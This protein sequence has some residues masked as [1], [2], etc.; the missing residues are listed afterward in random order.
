MVVN[1][2]K[3]SWRPV[4]SGVP[5]GSVLGPV[6]FNTFI[7]DLDKGIECTLIKFAD[8]TKLCGSVDLLE[9]RQALQRD[10]DRLDRWAGVNCMRFNKA[11]CKVLHLGH[12]NPMQRY[13]LGEEWLESCP[14]EKDL[15][16]LVNSRLNMS[17]QCAQVA[18]KA[19]GILACIKNSVASRSS[20]VIVP[21]YSALVRPHL[22][23]CVQFW[24]P[25]YKRDIEVLERVQRRATK[26]VKGLEQKSY[27]DRLRELGLFSLEKR[28]LRGDLIALYNYLKGGCREVGV[29]IFSQVTS[30]RMR[31]N[32]LKLRQGRFRLDIRK[33]YFTE[34]VV[35]HWNRLPREVVELPSLEVFKRHVCW[36]YNTAQRKQETRRFLECVE[37]NFQTQ[38]VSEPTREGA[39]L[40]LL[41]VNREGLAGDV[42]VGGCLGHSDHEVI[43][44]LILGEVRRG[45]SRTATLDFWR[46]DFGLFRGLADRVPW[47]AVLKGKGV[48][49]GWTFFKKKIVKAEEQAIP[50]CQKT[51]QQ[52]RQLAWLK[53]ELWLELRKKRRVYDL[54][55]KGQ[56]TQEDYKDVVRLCREKIRRTK[57][58]L[59]IN[60]ATAVKDNK[61]CFY[62]Y[63]SNKRT[64]KE[65]LHPLLDVG[66]NIVTKDEE[67][68]EVLNA[69]FASVFNSKTSC[70]PGTQPPELEDR[71][72]EQSEAP[73][74]QEEMVSDLLHHLDTNKSMGLGGMHPRVLRELVG[75]LTK[76]FSILYQQSWLTGEV[77]KCDAHLQEGLE[78]GLGELRA[79]QSD[80]GAEEVYG[81]DHL[82]CHH[83]AHTGHPGDQAQ[84]AWV[85]ERQDKVTCLVDEGKAV[86]VVYL[87]FSKAF[88]TVSHSILL[89]KLAAHG[90]DGCML[91]WLENCL[92]GWVQRV[93]V[94]GVKSSRWLVTSGVP[95]GSVL[96]PVLFNVFISDLDEGIKYTLI[97]FADDTTL[98]RNVD[99]LESRKILQRDLDRL[100]RWAKTNCMRFNKAKCWVLHL[101]HKNPM[102][103]YRLGE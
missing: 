43:E 14:M 26:L 47:E 59:E 31:G 67:K 100:D 103:H 84:P 58:Q 29:G 61:K 77:S 22:E 70:S 40:E 78:G 62:K 2:V 88:D 72:G 13:S 54:W 11:K 50:M 69:F 30:D 97:K 37:D 46:A 35:Q 93:L 20:E 101:G 65:N 87:D 83:T 36:K 25:H 28:R 91:C 99:L 66:G 64:A 57:A 79:C 71:D 7:N 82:E 45:V 96:G 19:N 42:M 86:D 98:D 24:A 92:D 102:Q 23:Y 5:Q 27:E 1:G 55:K 9:G 51:S 17:Q 85:Y 74:I 68:A 34:R 75:V 10:L 73:I 90:L 4:T 38:L 60:M 53:R 39:L 16:V 63:I 15:G 80:L 48:Q 49:E 32:G 44:F 21:L 8:D 33:F 56:A 89:E 95:Q 76:P 12:S 81:A 52:G 3:S 18:K 41:F 6:L 94:S